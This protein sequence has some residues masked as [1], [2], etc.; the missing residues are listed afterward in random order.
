MSLPKPEIEKFT[1]GGDFSLWK[2]KM[3]ALLVHQGLEPALEE[4]DPE[5]AGSSRSDEK[6]KQIHNRAHSTLILSLSDSILREISE[7]KTALGIWNKVEALCMKKSL[8]HRLFLKKRLY[9]FFMKEG[10]SIQEHIDVFNKIILDLEGVES[11]KIGDE[12]KAFF[13]LSS[14]P[15]S[16]EG[17]VDTMLY[18]RTTL[19]LE[20]VKAS[21]CSKEI[22]RHSGDLDQN[23]GEGLMA[24]A[25]KKKDK[26]KKKNKNQFKKEDESEKEKMKRRKCFYCKKTGHYIRDCAEKKRD[27]KEKSGDAAVASD[28]SSDG[29][30][31]SADLLVASNGKIEGQWVLDT[32]CSFHMSPDKTLFHEYETID[33]GR[34]LMGNHNACKIVGISSVKIRMYDGMTRTLE[35][36]RHVPGLKKNL[37]SLGMLDSSGYVFK[38]DHGGLKVMKNSSIVMKG[39]KNNGLYVLEGSSVHVLSAL[40]ASSDVDKAKM[41]HLRLGHMSAKSLQE[42]TK[43]GLLCGDKVEELKFCENCIFGK[44]HRIKFER[45]LH[46]SK[47]VLD[48]AHSDLWGPAQVPSLSGGRYFVTFI[49]DF[50]RKVWLYILKTKD[51]AFEKFKIWRALVE[52]QSGVKLKA[53]RTDNGLEFCNKEFDEYCQKHGITRHKTVRSPSAALKFKTPEEIWTGVSADYKHLRIFGCTAYVHVKQGK[54]D[55]RALKGVFVGYPEGVKGYKVWCGATHKCIISRDVTFNEESM[56]EDNDSAVFDFSPYTDESIKEAAIRKDSRIEVESSSSSDREGQDMGAPE[57][58]QERSEVDDLRTPVTELQDYQLARDRARRETKPPSRYAYAGMIAYALNSAEEIAIEEPASYRE[59]VKGSDSSNW[60]KAMEEEMDSLNKNKTWTLVQD[61]GNRRLVSCKWIFKRKEGIPGA[62]ASRF[63]A[64]LVA[65]GFTQK[66][67]VD[68]TEVFSPVVKHSSI[69]MLLSMVALT[70]MEL[71]QMDVKTAFLHGKLE[72]EILMTQ[73]EGFEIKGKEDHVCHLNKSLYGLKQSPRQWYK[74]FDEFMISKGYLR[75]KY[76]SCV[77]SGSS[78]S[79]GAVYLLLYVDDMLLASKDRS[80]IKKLKDLLNAE[81][82]MKDLG[83]AKR[84]LGMDIIRNRA[85]GTIFVSQE[86]YILK[87]LDRFD[88]LDAK[89]VQTPLGSQFKLSKMQAPVTDQDKS[90]MSEVP[91]AQAVGSLMYAMVCTRADIA[92]AVSLV[93]R[94][95][96]DPGKEHWDA[97]KWIMRY[98]RGTPDHG[99]LY[100]R[101][102]QD[103]KSIVGYVDSDF[104][105]DLDGRKSISGYLFMVNGCLISWKATLQSVVTLSS[106]EAEFVAA[107]KAVKEGKWLG[108][109]LNELW[110]KQKTFT[111]FC[112]N[113]SAIHLIKNQIYHERTKHIDVRLHF[114]RDEVS[115]GAVSVNKIHTDINPAD[116]LTKVVPTAKFKFCVNLM[117]IMANLQ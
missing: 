29:G 78:N 45:G 6:M 112:D 55:S 21:L 60:I 98:L 84:I 56:L 31:Q 20:D 100:G 9:T 24:K 107:T 40:H 5:T 85:A 13:L 19:T 38:S 86:R 87:V 66:E 90:L 11:I 95:M 109:I 33:G 110:L 36:V 117:G 64:R 113:Q 34:V 76:D 39:V 18:G 47:A 4:E 53:L 106:T 7:E 51:Q 97:V 67:G 35:H 99:L 57:D 104:A 48:Y 108:G 43:R 42:L 3:R 26:K 63:K 10:V 105:G 44:A 52:N 54:L 49:D 15:K 2:M 72:E 27:S 61:P 58:L 79:G 93:S 17:F 50:S 96:S 65:R 92:Y 69:R 91:Y 89:S 71:D 88:M 101:S 41:W 73:P 75:S 12:D 32:G 74:R 23:P 30:Y 59:A 8:A 116:A 28:E 81:F 14:L 114:I 83:C 25:E 62:E 111:I 82:E 1:I 16:Y 70:D 37:I 94:F 80:E 102:K 22:Q 46:K 115:K 77:Y 103:E 68:F